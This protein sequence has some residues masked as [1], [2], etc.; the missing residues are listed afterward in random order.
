VTEHR[1]YG[2]GREGHSGLRLPPGR[3]PTLPPFEN[4]NGVATSSSPSERAWEGNGDV[5]TGLTP[6]SCQD[7][8]LPPFA[9]AIGVGP[10]L[11][12]DRGYGS[13]T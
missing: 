1:R 8:P 10:L 2:F 7:A 6:G 3:I 4:R 12:A 9:G 13:G 5:A 11:S